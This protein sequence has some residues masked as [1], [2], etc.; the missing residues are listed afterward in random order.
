MGQAWPEPNADTA[1]R[2]FE[3]PLQTPKMLR[4]PRPFSEG[5]GPLLLTEVPPRCN[6]PH[7]QNAACRT[8]WSLGV[9][10][11][12]R[13]G[14]LAALGVQAQHKSDGTVGQ[15]LGFSTGPPLPSLPT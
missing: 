12:W 1:T 8:S 13:R 14:Y 9:P 10:T 5:S 4:R 7:T 11:D 15:L 6:S 2:P 3:A